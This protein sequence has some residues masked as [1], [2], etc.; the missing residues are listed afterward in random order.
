M[1]PTKSRHRERG[2]LAKLLARGTD[3]HYQDAVLYDFEYEEQQED[4]RWY[5]ATVREHLPRGQVLELGAGTGRITLPLLEDGHRVVALDRKKEMLARLRDKLDD[6][7]A[8]RVQIET[9]DICALPFDD[10]SMHMVIAPFNVLMHL[11]T[12]DRLLACFQ[13]VS[14]VLRPG[15][16]FCFD[17]LLPDLEW[18]LLDPDRYHCRTRFIHPVT[19]APM[20]YSTNHTYDHASQ[21]AHIRIHYHAAAGRS[22]RIPA[23]A[24]PVSTV[25]LAHRQIWP[26]EIRCLL[27][28]AGLTLR[29]LDGDFDGLALTV[30]AE[31]Q[32]VIAQKPTRARA[33]KP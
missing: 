9:G 17:V 19:G 12:W 2:P 22:A 5:R 20:I 7:R 6:T 30:E 23:G 26:E 16:R 18:L 31:S 11:Y 15:G 24:R 29:S 14:R 27:H 13:E 10:A 32:V 3:E 21:V 1:A 28:M 8:D 4:V 33:R 25:Q